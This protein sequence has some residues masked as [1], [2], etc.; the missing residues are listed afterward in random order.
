MNEKGKNKNI[1]SDIS[2]HIKVRNLPEAGDASMV[3]SAIDVK[4]SEVLQS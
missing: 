3:G 1:Y 4:I 2:M